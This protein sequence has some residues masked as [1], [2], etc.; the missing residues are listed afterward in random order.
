MPTR[1]RSGCLP[2]PA[3]RFFARSSTAKLAP[4]RSAISG[5]ATCGQP[6][7]GLAVPDYAEHHGVTR[8]TH[9]ALSGM[10][11]RNEG[12]IINISSVMALSSLPISSV[13]SDTRAFVLA[14]IRGLQQ[15][16]A[17]T[18]VKVRVVLSAATATD[19]WCNS[20]VALSVLTPGSVMPTVDLVDAALSALDK[21]EDITWP[22]VAEMEM[23]E[24]FE[25][26][27]VALFSASQTGEVAPRLL[28]V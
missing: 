28:R 8:L 11:V 22:S 9:A 10:K 6:L 4:I 13:Y 21:G 3:S 15:E 20:G 12:T 23:I 17:E 24:R 19:V 27:R 1:L 7:G 16:L 26:A 18:G 25:S 2:T 14:F 5:I